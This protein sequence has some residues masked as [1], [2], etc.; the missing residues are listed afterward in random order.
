VISI[1]QELLNLAGG[2]Q[3]TVPLHETMA[4]LC[5]YPDVKSS[6]LQQQQ[7]IIVKF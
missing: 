2:G 7:K 5:I 4:L 3:K 1:L 6:A